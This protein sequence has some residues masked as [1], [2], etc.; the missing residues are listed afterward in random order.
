MLSLNIKSDVPF[1]LNL[2]VIKAKAIARY[3]ASLVD[4]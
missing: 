1:Y 2:Y 3:L 4:E